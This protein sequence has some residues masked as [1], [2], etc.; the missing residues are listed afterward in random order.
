MSES[1]LHPLQIFA[2]SLISI[3]LFLYLMNIG[4]FILVPLVW[5][6]FFAFALYPVSKWLESHLLPRSFSIAISIV[7]VTAIGA[8]VIYILVNQMVLL[9]SDIPEMNTLLQEKMDKYWAELQTTF[10]IDNYLIREKL[11]SIEWFADGNFNET[12]FNTGRSITL[13]GIIPLYIFL[14]LYYRDFFVA[15]LLKVSSKRNEAIL[16]W[17]ADAGKV[18]HAYLIG[19]VKVTFFV[20]L[21]SGIYFYFFGIKYYL[22]FAL[23]I[24]ILNLI[25]YI[26]VAISSILVIFYVF[27]TSD[28]IFAP[29][30][31]LAVLWGIQL[32]ENNLI[33]PLVVGA[34][35]KVNVLAVL[36]AVLIGGSVWG[37]SGMVLFIPM[38][39][40]LKITFDSIP[41]L[42]P[43]GYLLGDDFPQV[44]KGPSIFQYLKHKWAK[45]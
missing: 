29:A 14:L 41:S 22:L 45:K 40:V 27:L 5:G 26:G 9:L 39:G 8:A 12:L 42:Q 37:I 11:Q 32:I 24:A 17:V 1:K 30:L 15:F 7:I 31:T 25:P 4:A 21:L 10:G 13:I 44:D 20:A 19:M 6:V 43:Y 23:F 18:I 33:T 34:K 28:T 35:V 38:V 2:Y 16:K 36:L 3:A